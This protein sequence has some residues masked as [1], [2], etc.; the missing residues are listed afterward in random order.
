MRNGNIFEISIN[1]Q[2]AQVTPQS[3]T[4]T[5]KKLSKEE[6]RV[7]RLTD[8]NGNWLSTEKTAKSKKKSSKKSSRGLLTLKKHTFLRTRIAQKCEKERERI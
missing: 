8:A 7:K 2:F 1:K 3:K 4:L 5:T 6:K